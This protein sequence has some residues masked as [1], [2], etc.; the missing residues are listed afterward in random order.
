[1]NTSPT[2]APVPA[3]QAA[4]LVAARALG[5]LHRNRS[6]GALPP[7]TTAELAD[8]DSVYKPLGES[9]LAASLVL[10]EGMASV[11]DQ[12]AARDMMDFAWTQLGSGDLLYER[13]LRYPLITDPLEVYAYFARVGYRHQR[14]D[15]LLDHL[16][17]LTA[18][19]GTEML[20]NRR[21]AVANAARVAGVPRQVDWGELIDATWL[22][23]APEPWMIDWLT[24]YCMTHSVFN[25]TDW[26]ARADELP[27]VARDY[28]TDW[29]PVWMDIW[30]ETQEWD[31]VGELIIVDA[32]LPRPSCEP[33]VW[34]RF[35]AAQHPDGLMPRNGEPVDEDP[36]KA[37]RDHHHTVVVASVAGTLALSRYHD[38][39]A[40]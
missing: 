1:M 20:P 36:A 38:A 21:L 30:L 37:F 4:H 15:T 29:L 10:R 14:L 22:G 19:R 28:L 9:A 13:Q 5:W 27:P 8:P 33:E 2:G 23:R 12:R 34:E 11:A 40:V 26:G 7:D 32:C 35:A 6:L 24:A 31:L 39:A 16:G 18:H 3:R 25:A 17:S